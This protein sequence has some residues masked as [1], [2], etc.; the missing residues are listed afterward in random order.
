M[1]PRDP[2]TR[3]LTYVVDILEAVERRREEGRLPLRGTAPP[4]LRVEPQ[5]ALGLEQ[6]R[7][8]TIA[9]KD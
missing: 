9:R 4:A 5:S 6:S 1:T 3:S 2:L 7:V 8:S